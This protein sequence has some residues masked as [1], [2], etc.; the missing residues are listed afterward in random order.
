MIP[1]IGHLALWFALAF[2]ILASWIPLWGA[3]K[4]DLLS[5]SFAKPFALAQFF[6]VAV[7]F[8]C[9]TWAFERNDFTVA[10]VANHSNTL[11]PSRYKF[12]A[13]W[14]GHE[15]SILLWCL[16]LTGWSAAVAVNSRH[17]PID[18][19]A[20]VLSVLGMINVGFLLFILL[21]SNPFDRLLPNF[22]LEG[23]DLNPLL[24]D[25]GLIVHPPILYMGYV[26]FSVAFAFAV[27]GLLSG[28]LD[29]TWARWLRPWTLAAWSFLTLGIALGSWWAYYELGWGGWWFWDPVE[30]A[31]FMPWL[32][33]TALLHSLS[34]T[35]KRG[36]FK[37]W[38][39]LL[40]VS[41]FSLSLLGTFLVRSG[42]L[43]SVHAFAND[44]ERGL[45]ILIF[46]M[47]VIGGSLTLFALRAHKIS[48][49]AQY[50]AV[51]RE[52][53]ILFNNVLL[54]A[55]TLVV[56]VGTLFPLV[57]DVMEWG[58]FSIGAPYFNTIFVPVG[59]VLLT[60]I[61]VGPVLRWKKDKPYRLLQTL[62][63]PAA[64]SV[65]IGLSIPFVLNK[66]HPLA[67]VSSVIAAWVIVTTLIEMKRQITHGRHW[68]AG[69]A[70]LP[71]SLQ[72]MA[73]AHMGVAVTVLGI[74]FTSL[75]SEERTVRVVPGDELTLAGYH[76]QYHLTQSVAGPNFWAEQ[77]HLTVRRQ[78]ETVSQLY[79]ERRFYY[80]QQNPMTE[81]AIDAGLMRDIYVALGEPLATEGDDLPRAVRVQYK[82]MV[83]WIWLGGLMMAIGG[84]LCIAD[85]RYRAKRYV[86][87]P[88]VTGASLSS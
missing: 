60:I 9:L 13:V 76:I 6:F 36:V 52:S 86:Q 28:N 51:S 58:K 48:S 24:Q 64:V 80:S 53:G 47:I 16:I 20:R 19:I 14:G 8:I 26:G 3:Y 62:R 85:K 33:G 79:P 42:V 4:Q 43:T 37:A 1:E 35:E 68:V 34:A 21:T 88:K 78:D 30:N 18:L 31:S 73:W 15:G 39:L 17:L 87:R 29:A 5:L 84:G 82:P 41:A 40:A 45:F 32:A 46:L 77:A 23:R 25:F 54:V 59:L 2:A 66:T 65:L 69:F 70:K 63:V 61:G 56:L 7:A 27:A 22:P 57:A 12:S 44:P 38:T 50:E 49:S 81:A 67:L 83:R 10:Y 11:L 71:L 75:Y 74:T 55:L 72:G